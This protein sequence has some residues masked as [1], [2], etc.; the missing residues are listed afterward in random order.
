M[1]K[2]PFDTVVPVYSGGGTGTPDAFKFN[3]TCRV[4][5]ITRELSQAPPPLLYDL[6]ITYV[7]PVL[8]VGSWTPTSGAIDI[9]LT[10]A[11]YVEY[12]VGSSVYYMVVR[13]SIVRPLR[14]GLTNYRRAFCRLKDY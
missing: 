8:S 11:D 7:S 13:Q 4:V 3:L 2:A 5:P 1:P 9:D 12:P 14:A 6:Y 10:Q